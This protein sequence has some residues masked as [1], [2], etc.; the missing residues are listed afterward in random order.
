[1]A[2]TASVAASVITAIFVS[3]HETRNIEKR[4]MRKYRIMCS[5]LLIVKFSDLANG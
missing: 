2:V 4:M 1:M 5:S 3:S